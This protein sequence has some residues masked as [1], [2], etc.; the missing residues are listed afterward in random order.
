MEK[1][2]LL[3]QACRLPP[4][5]WRL[6]FKA[7]L[8]LSKTCPAVCDTINDGTTPTLTCISPLTRESPLTATLVEHENVPL[9]RTLRKHCWQR[10]SQG[11]RRRCCCPGRSY[12]SAYRFAIGYKHMLH[13]HY[14]FDA[15]RMKKFC[16]CAG[17]D[18]GLICCEICSNKTRIAEVV[19]PIWAVW[20]SQAY[21]RNAI[22]PFFLSSSF[23]VWC[24]KQECA[25]VFKEQNRP[26]AFSG[27]RE[28]FLIL[29]NGSGPNAWLIRSVASFQSSVTGKVSTLGDSKK[30]RSR[31]KP[32]G[33]GTTVKLVTK[34]L[35]EISKGQNMYKMYPLLCIRA[36]CLLLFIQ[37]SRN[38]GSSR[39]HT[40]L[41]G[42]KYAQQRNAATTR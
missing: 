27:R 18:H 9:T 6:A 23:G 42:R 31:L 3:L 8:L 25:L 34:I 29:V 5:V 15:M 30:E 14:V 41:L 28:S 12:Q 4:M 1:P 40:A 11:S 22:P 20:P 17:T 35:V 16:E 33:R 36:Y 37:A 19:K 10:V 2:P 38:E 13:C 26:F 24:G 39:M 32:Q 21:L 7:R